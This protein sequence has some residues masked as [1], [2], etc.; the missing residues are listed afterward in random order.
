MIALAGRASPGRA[1]GM[2]PGAPG[3]Q[4]MESLLVSGCWAS[5]GLG[6]GAGTMGCW[7]LDGAPKC[8][9]KASF[10]FPFIPTLAE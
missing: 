7:R 3:A 8:V 10:K 6:W 9:K 4:R 2:R 1:C 5:A